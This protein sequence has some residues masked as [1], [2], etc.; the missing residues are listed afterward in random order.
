MSRAPLTQVNAVAPDVGSG[1]IHDHVHPAAGPVMPRQ[2]SDPYRMVG[3]LPDEEGQWR[4][5][6]VSDLTNVALED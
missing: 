3:P 5:L 2:A 1:I 4:W 6:I